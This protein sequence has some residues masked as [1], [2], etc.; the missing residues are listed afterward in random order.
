MHADT[1]LWQSAGRC[2]CGSSSLLLNRCVTCPTLEVEH[3][4]ATSPA[5]R[6]LE[7]VLELDFDTQRFAV[8]WGDV[9]AEEAMALKVLVQERDKWTAELRKREADDADMRRRVEGAQRRAGQ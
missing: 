1:P 4:R 5:G 9:T 2:A 3:A 6:L 8:P 7:R